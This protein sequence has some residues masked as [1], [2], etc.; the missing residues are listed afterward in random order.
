[1]SVIAEVSEAFPLCTGSTEADRGRLA[2]VL[3]R[4]RTVDPGCQRVDLL[5]V[6]EPHL[7]F[8]ELAFTV[9]TRAMLGA[10]LALLLSEKLTAEQRKAVGTTLT[11]VGLLT[12]IPAVWAVC[13]RCD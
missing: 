4:C 10:G 2:L 9:A 11:V 5:I 13:G 12:T 7:S 3:Q 8:P 1:M 6:K